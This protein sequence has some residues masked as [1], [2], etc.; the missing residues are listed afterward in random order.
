MTTERF[1]TQAA[2][3]LY[4]GAGAGD[5]SIQVQ[6]ATHFPTKPEFRVRIGQELLLVTGVAG[7]TW[8]VTRGIEGTTAADHAAG[9]SG[10]VLQEQRPAL[11]TGNEGA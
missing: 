3:T 8:T 2:T 11:R 6:D 5:L 7:A 4:A 1:S 9:G 10:A